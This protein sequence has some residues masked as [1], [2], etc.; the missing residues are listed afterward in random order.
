L[1][2]LPVPSH[3]AFRNH[4]NVG[5]LGQDHAAWEGAIFN[6]EWC[7]E[8]LKLSRTAIDKE[9]FD[10]LLVW[11]DL[12][13]AQL[14]NFRKMHFK[15]ALDRWKEMFSSLPQDNDGLAIAVYFY[16]HAGMYQ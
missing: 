11:T 5:L 2:Q 6:F 14:Y 12:P 1:H 3:L 16:V 8:L 4:S 13:L 10:W 7:R 15:K 9:S